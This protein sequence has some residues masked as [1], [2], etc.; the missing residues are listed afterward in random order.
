[1]GLRVLSVLVFTLLVSVLHVTS[2][3]AAISVFATGM[4]QPETITQTVSGSFFVTDADNQGTIW[5]VSAG[6]GTASSL[7]KAGYSLRG[8]LILPAN[9]GSVGGQ[10]LV[11]GLKGNGTAQAS[12]MDANFKVTRYASQADSIW[13]QPVLAP[14]FG[15][16]GGGVLVTNQGV[17]TVPGSVDVFRSSG[18]VGRLAPLSAVN[19][20]FGA[21]LAPSGFGDVGG[22]LLVS[23]AGGFSAVSGQPCSPTTIPC[24]GIYSVNPVGHVSLFTTIPLGAG[25]NGLRQIAFAPSGWGRCSGNLFVSVDNTDID[26]VNSDGAVVGKISGMFSPRGL[27][28]TTLSSGPSLL[29]SDISTG[30]ILRAGPGDVA[31]VC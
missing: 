11:V 27:L 12:T 16:F 10:F 18:E 9:F 21:D 6:G 8:G 20:P 31:P 2:V 13:T 15:A 3:S 17:D 5:N 22:T 24:S 26:V 30:R 25:Q 4:H 14:R 19:T 28:F 7:A 1:M 23:D 29:F